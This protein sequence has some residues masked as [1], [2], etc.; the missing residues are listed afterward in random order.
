MFASDL[1]LDHIGQ[2][3]TITIGTRRVG[4]IIRS[5]QH[6]HIFDTIAVDLDGLTYQLD[7]SKPVELNAPD[8]VPYTDL[9]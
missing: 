2:D 5:V 1:T 8:A 3:L 9:Y 4:G 7:P 6:V